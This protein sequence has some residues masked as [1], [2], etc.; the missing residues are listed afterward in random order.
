MHL[1][2]RRKNQIGVF[3]GQRASGADLAQ[4]HQMKELL[5]TDR[6]SFEN[7]G[8]SD[9]LRM[10]LN[11]CRNRIDQF[12]GHAE[13]CVPSDQRGPLESPLALDLPFVN[14]EVQELIS[15][16]ELRNLV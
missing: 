13:P 3:N 7:S 2:S 5:S 11:E 10:S 8:D 12:I 6:A 9:A 1:L 14:D 16:K 4:G 15:H